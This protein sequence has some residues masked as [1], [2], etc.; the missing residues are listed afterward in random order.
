[1]SQES[2]SYTYTIIREGNG[3]PSRFWH[4]TAQPDSQNW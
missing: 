4:S 1:M 2:K 3:L